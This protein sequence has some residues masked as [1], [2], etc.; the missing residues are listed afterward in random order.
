MG[1]AVGQVKYV[2]QFKRKVLGEQ[3]NGQKCGGGGGGG[4]RRKS[5]Q[6]APDGAV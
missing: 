6:R 1:T 2:R 5:V 3:Q 4:G